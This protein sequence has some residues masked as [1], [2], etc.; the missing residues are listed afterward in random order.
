LTLSAVPY[1][2]ALPTEGARR[3]LEEA[4]AIDTDALGADHPETVA[5][6]RDLKRVADAIAMPRG[7]ASDLE[8][9]PPWVIFD[10]L[11]GM[12]GGS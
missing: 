1:D 11:P 6:A 12:R 7:R 3:R 2:V 8:A 10:A 9:D 4:L 5:I